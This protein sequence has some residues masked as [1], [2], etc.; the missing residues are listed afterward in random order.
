MITL[1]V[2]FEYGFV[3]IT[4][5]I[6][7]TLTN[8][9]LGGPVMQARKTLNVPYP[10][11]YATPVRFYF[12]VC[13][14]FHSISQSTSHV[15]LF[16]FPPCQ[17]MNAK[18]GVHKEADAFNRIQRGHQNFLENI[19]DFRFLALVGGLKHPGICS[20]AGLVFCLGSILYQKGY[21][22]LI[23]FSSSSYE[24][25]WIYIL[26]FIYVT[27]SGPIS[28]CTKGKAFERW[29]HQMDRIL[30]RTNVLF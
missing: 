17:C 9:F 21:G 11:L 13:G 28:G 25:R 15:F 23:L 3:I 8:I 22:M 6:G 24:C 10:N 16:S 26:T 29:T 20:V 14:K 30:I 27:H 12:L 2:P 19:G 7:P 1:R 4:C 18:K 5:V